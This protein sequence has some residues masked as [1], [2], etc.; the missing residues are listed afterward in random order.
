MPGARRRIAGREPGAAR[1]AGHARCFRATPQGRAEQ[2]PAGER[3]ETAVS[4]DQY[5]QQDPT[6][7]YAQGQPEQQ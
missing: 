6:Q 1:A 7:Q 3:E 2:D 5:T 4:E